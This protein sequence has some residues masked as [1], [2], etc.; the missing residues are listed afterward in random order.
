MRGSGAPEL[1]ARRARADVLRG[2]APDLPPVVGPL[3]PR[4]GKTADM[5][6]PRGLA[7]F[8]RRVTNHVMRPIARR[9]PGLAVV[10]HVG[11]RSGRI[12][13]TPVN[14]FHRDDDVFFALTYGDSSWVDNVMAAGGCS[15]RTRGHVI[16][17]TDPVRFTDTDR[18]DVPQPARAILGLVHV[19]EFLSMKPVR[20]R[21]T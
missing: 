17:L 21:P 1:A 14:V 3:T 4:T 20:R 10:R 7:R 5:P 6:L 9:L 19:D 13:E 15:I 12:Y 11:R 2:A 8:N 16:E 18:S